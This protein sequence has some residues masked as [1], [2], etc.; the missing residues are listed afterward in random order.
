MSEIGIGIV[1]LRNNGM[2]HARRVVDLDGC[3]LAA[4]ADVDA[5]RTRA[6]AE[7]AGGVTEYAAAK[8]LFADP[9]GEGVLLSLP[10][11]LH[12]PLSIAALEAGKHVLV[13]KPM[14]MTAAEAR[15]MIKAREIGSAHV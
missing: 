5:E 1:G 4:A 13:E 3:R 11:H 2:G 7:L 14:S 15:D 8:D 12:A 9:E 10:N 6:A